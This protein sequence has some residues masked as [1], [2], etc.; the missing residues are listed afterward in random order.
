MALKR[1]ERH[2]PH[3]ISGIINWIIDNLIWPVAYVCPFA[4]QCDRSSKS[5]SLCF[6]VEL[7]SHLC[8]DW[9]RFM[10]EHK[11]IKKEEPRS[12]AHA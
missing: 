5:N 10:L 7:F 12:K 3:K 9:R 2:A 1:L 6:D 8:I 11:S 4:H